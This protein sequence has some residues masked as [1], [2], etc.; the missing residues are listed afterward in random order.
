MS[1]F[2]V[3]LL[4]D[5]QY[6]SHYLDYRLLNFAFLFKDQVIY[7]LNKVVDVA[8]LPYFYKRLTFLGNYFERHLVPCCFQLQRVETQALC[9][10]FRRTSQIACLCRV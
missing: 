8:E 3:A 1:R 10:Y 4:V 6:P 7:N 2:S 5:Q 9:K